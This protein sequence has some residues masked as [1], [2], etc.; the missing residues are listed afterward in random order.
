MNVPQHIVAKAVD[1]DLVLLNVKDGTYYKLNPTGA[2]LWERL[3]A[4]ATEAEAAQALAAHFETTL[5]TATADTKELL[6]QLVAEGL[7]VSP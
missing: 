7:V 2:F 4:G 6:E 3:R 1:N 5:E